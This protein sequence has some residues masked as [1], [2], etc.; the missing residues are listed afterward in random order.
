MRK[1]SLLVGPKLAMY[2]GDGRGHFT[3]VTPDNVFYC[4][5][6]TAYAYGI[7]SG[8]GDGTFQPNNSATRGQI[9]KIVYLAV[10]RP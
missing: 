8:Y 6:E 9:C 5:I 7:I 4:S 10:T 3:D 2:R 1:M